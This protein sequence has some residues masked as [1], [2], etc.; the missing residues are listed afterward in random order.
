MK[1]FFVFAAAA[2]F[3][4]VAC[5]KT[6]PQ[7]DGSGNGDNGSGAGTTAGVYYATEDE[8]KAEAACS[9]NS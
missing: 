3:A 9:R 8:R 5:D 2:A 4:L 7:V 6:G 1:K